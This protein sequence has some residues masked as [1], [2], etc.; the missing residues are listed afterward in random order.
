MVIYLQIKVLQNQQVFIPE[1]HCDV[2]MDK[3]C[4]DEDEEYNDY[5]EIGYMPEK[6][7]VA[8]KMKEEKY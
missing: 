6:G 8:R 2:Y 5:V 4:E 1:P 7:M 3:D